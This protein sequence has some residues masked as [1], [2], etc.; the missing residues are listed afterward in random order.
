VKAIIDRLVVDEPSF[1][2]EGS[3]VWNALP[4]TL[5]AIARY[6]RPGDRTV[7]TGAGASTVVF[8]AARA[9]HLAISPSADEHD[10]IQ[11]YCRD[12]GVETDAI[13]FA[14]AS[15]SDLLPT[16]P[17]DTEW[18]VAFIDGRHSFPGPVIDWFFV[19]ERLRID[20]HIII[21]DVPIPAVRVVY[22]YMWSAPEWRLV[23]IIDDRAAVFRKVMPSDA[24][25]NW[26]LQPFNAG[27]PDYSFL[28]LRRRA[29][30]GAAE[31]ATTLRRR[32]SQRFPRLRDRWKRRSL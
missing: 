24:V 30:V 14:S 2:L 4:A 21:D 12:I 11:A 3:R 6:V 13:S 27:Y 20:G 18:D 15:S 28:P 29:Q 22:D 32:L 17:T 8:A 19:A 23:E 5:T 10:R 9:N 25:D 16:M 31:R 7:E 1:H 26:R